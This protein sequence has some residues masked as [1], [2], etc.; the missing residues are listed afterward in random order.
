[1]QNNPLNRNAV[2]YDDKLK[3]YDLGHVLKEDRYQNFIDLFQST[4]GH[5]PD[6]D[7]VSPPYATEEDLKLL[8]TEEY[9]RRIERCESRDPHDTPLSPAFVRAAKLLAGAGKFA[10]ELI[11]SGRYQRAFVVGGGVQHATR[12]REKGFGVF[13][14]IGL[15]AENLMQNFHVERIM[16]VDTDAHAGDG[17]YDIYSQD[18]RVLFISIHQHPLTLYPG[19]GFVDEIGREEGTGY[20]VNIPMP[21]GAGDH[22]YEC[23][24]D[25]IIVPLS[26]SFLPRIV[27]LVDGCDTHF[28]DQITQMG[29]TLEGIRMIGEKMGQLASNMCDG[30][31]V[32]FVGSGYSHDPNIVSSGWLASISGITGIPVDLEGIES[33]PPYVNPD[34][35][36]KGTR[37]IARLVRN[38]LAPYWGF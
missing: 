22:C 1:M 4:L 15:C 13:S 8:H 6:F 21:P 27:L 2:V 24:L 30:K 20:S 3:E 7:I 18:P 12:D 34:N 14:D 36:L 38:Q 16:I 31:I 37:E 33:T 29:L 9:I 25:E 32:D 28:T 23:I 26:E 11:Q 10:G 35:G 5:R 19:K 17:I